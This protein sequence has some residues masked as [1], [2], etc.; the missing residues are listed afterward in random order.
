MRETYLTT[1]ASVPA[2]DVPSP[3]DTYIFLG[4]YVEALDFIYYNQHGYSLT[5]PLALYHGIVT[6]DTFL[7]IRYLSM[8]AYVRVR[9]AVMREII[10]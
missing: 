9:D 7:T 1:T 5:A 4:N 10:L 8:R 2:P 6:S 3:W